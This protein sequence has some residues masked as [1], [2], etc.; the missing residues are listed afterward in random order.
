ME[1]HEQKKAETPDQ[2]PGGI[3]RN[4]SHGSLP[5]TGSHGTLPRTGSHGTLPRTGSA[6]NLHPRS[7]SVGSRPDNDD[8]KQFSN[9][10]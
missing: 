7:N 8:G 3:S 4:S 10:Y 1:Q 9:L 5:R 6:S 2:P